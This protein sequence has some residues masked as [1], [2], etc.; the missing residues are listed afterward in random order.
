M[1]E[2]NPN[3]EYFTKEEVESLAKKLEDWGGKLPDGE[4]QLLEFLVA[5]AEMP[6][7][8]TAEELIIVDKTIQKAAYSALE[9]FINKNRQK[10]EN[11]ILWRR[12]SA[13]TR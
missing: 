1:S 6:Y 7:P 13:A 11:C 9:D 5:R 12:T 8:E 3:G 2:K 4:R 10:K